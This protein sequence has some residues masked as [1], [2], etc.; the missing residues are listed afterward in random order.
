M[1]EMSFQFIL[2]KTM[3]IAKQARLEKMEGFVLN[4]G[5]QLECDFLRAEINA[6]KN[7]A[8]ELGLEAKL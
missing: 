1:H 8:N 7:E 5:V 4:M 6:L 2:I 3:I